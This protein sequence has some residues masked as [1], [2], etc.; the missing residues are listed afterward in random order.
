MLLIEKSDKILD[1]QCTL[2]LRNDYP[3]IALSTSL[4]ASIPGIAIMSGDYVEMILFVPK[5]SDNSR[6]M[7]IFLDRFNAFDLG[8]MWAIRAKSTEYP[9]VETFRMITGV[10]SVVLDGMI[11]SGG[12]LRVNVRFSHEHSAEVS[13][14][15]MKAS[16]GISGLVPVYLGKSRGALSF[17]KEI[18]TSIPLD[19]ISLS[20]FPPQEEKVEERNPVPGSWVREIRYMTEEDI[21]AVY[22]SG[23]QDTDNS[24]EYAGVTGTRFETRTSNKVLQMIQAETVTIPIPTFFRSQGFDGSRFQMDFAVPRDYSSGFLKI[25]AG[26]GEKFKEWNISIASI[27]PFD[28]IIK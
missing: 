22:L 4:K 10:P 7:K 28:E 25:V 6:D 2:E 23:L 16:S 20:S 8:A 13:E 19:Y 27:I 18:N 26:V 12:A 9:P 5:S 21:D 1:R 3:V 14:A 24:S 17:L 11:L 15:I